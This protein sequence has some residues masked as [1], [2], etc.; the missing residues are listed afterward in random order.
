MLANVSSSALL[1]GEEPPRHGNAHPSIAPYEVFPTADG[2]LFLAVGNDLQWR[3]LAAILGEDAWGQES[4][5]ATNPARVADRVA[6]VAAIAERTR[7]WSRQEL[8]DELRKAGIPAGPLRTVVEALGDPAF[9]G[10]GGRVEHADGTATVASPLRVGNRLPRH[11]AP[12]PR[13]GEHTLE[14]LRE[15]GESDAR[16]LDL[17]RRGIV[18]GPGV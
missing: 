2:E 4:R 10:R 16:V 8:L 18:S 17:G 11:V 14:V 12:A 9:K 5:W 1:T 3:C 7:G 6:V 15:L 13:L